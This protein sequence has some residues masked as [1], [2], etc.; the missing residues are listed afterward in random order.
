VGPV[1]IIDPC[2]PND[3]P[4]FEVSVRHGSARY[5]IRVDNP[6]GVNRGVAVAELDGVAIGVEPLTVVLRDDDRVH[7]LRIVLGSGENGAAAQAPA[8]QRPVRIA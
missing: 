1:L 3:W 5:D 4:F 6:G 8:Q 7:S 2:I